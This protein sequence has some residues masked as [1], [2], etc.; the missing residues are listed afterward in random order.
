MKKVF[1]FPGQGSQKIGM[2]KELYDGFSVFKETI[3]QAEDTISLN[4]SKIMFNGP[5]HVL[6]D[7]ENTQPIL[8]ASS[9]ATLNTIQ[10]NFPDF[11][12]HAAGGHSLGE[13]SALVAIGALSFEDAILLVRKRGQFMK[14]ACSDGGMAA[15]IGLDYEELQKACNPECVIANDNCPG[16]LV[17][18]GLHGGLEK[19][20]AKAK[21]LGAKIIKKLPVS[22]PFH[23][24][25]MEKAQK[26]LEEIIDDITVHSF[27]IPYYPNVTAELSKDHMR[28]KTLLLSQITGAVRFREILLNMEKDMGDETAFYEIGPGKVLSGL[29]KRTCP[30]RVCT[31]INTSTDLESFQ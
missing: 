28:V 29:V 27:D 14:N 12:F 2:C 26:K 19:A 4:I 21:E 7:T 6:N 3:Q 1:L 17:L 8:V 11:K 30:D 18:S 23:S 15:V 25:W 10:K 20:M 31:P 16:Q 5:D 22:G 24:P 9:I 13:Y